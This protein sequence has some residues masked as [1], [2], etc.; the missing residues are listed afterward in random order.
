MPKNPAIPV[1]LHLIP[2]FQ[3]SVLLLLLLPYQPQFC[4]ERNA[5]RFILMNLDEDEFIDVVKIPLEKAVDMVMNNEIKDGKTKLI[6][7]M[8]ARILG[9]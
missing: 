4:S 2:L 1:R 9:I 5:N 8:A 6:I 3:N 7:L